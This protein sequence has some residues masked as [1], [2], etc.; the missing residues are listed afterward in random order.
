MCI[1]FACLQLFTVILT[2]YF[3][4]NFVKLSNSNLN[5]KTFKVT[6]I[7]DYQLIREKCMGRENIFYMLF[8]WSTLLNKNIY[9]YY[10]SAVE[11]F[12]KIISQ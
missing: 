8:Y 11:R 4:F 5:L 10:L 1:Y 6:Y 9:N 7:Q 12:Q 3:V 2:G